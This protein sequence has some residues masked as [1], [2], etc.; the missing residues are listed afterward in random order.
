MKPITLYYLLNIFLV[1][2]N[3][4]SLR[5]G[6]VTPLQKDLLSRVSDQDDMVFAQ[7]SRSSDPFDEVSEIIHMFHF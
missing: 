4:G 5:S 3:A 7:P 1:L 6:T 2:R